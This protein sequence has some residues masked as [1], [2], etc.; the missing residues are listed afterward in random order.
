M[1]NFI[2]EDR[3][4]LEFTCPISG[5]IY[6]QSFSRQFFQTEHLTFYPLR[7]HI[8]VQKRHE[9][10]CLNKQLI[11]CYHHHEINHSCLLWTHRACV[12]TRGT[13]F[14]SQNDGV[15][16]M[17]FIDFKWILVGLLCVL[18]DLHVRLCE[19]TFSLENAPKT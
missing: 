14:L 17:Y 6:K 16:D 2:G 1:F 4:P 11:G 15:K 9:N 8:L 5:N 7:S 19:S 3:F 13:R 12:Q 18:V 10:V